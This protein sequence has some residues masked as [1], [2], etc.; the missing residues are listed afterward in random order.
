MYKKSVPVLMYHHIRPEAGMIACTPENFEDQLRWL[1]KQ[2]YRSLSLSEFAQ[3]LQGKEVGK[4]V[5]ITFDDGYLNNWVYAFPLLLKY[6]FNATI[7]LVT[8]WLQ[9]GPIRP[10]MGQSDRLPDCP[11]HHACEALIEQGRSD[12]VIL[13]WSEVRAMRDSGLVEFH[14]HTDTHTRWDLS[15]PEEKNSR[16]RQELVSS[17]ATLQAELGE[18]SPHLCW[19]QGYFDDDY[20]A[21]AR[22][23]GFEYLYTTLAFGRNTNKTPASH[24][25]RFAVR[26]RP[27]KTLGKRIRSSHHPIIGPVFNT[28]KIWTRGLKSRLP[29]S[30]R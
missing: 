27:G 11:D 30:T 20:I 14:S 18:V 8:S 25:H 24:I 29:L 1:Q 4:A 23:V 7:F 16:I 10:Y 9:H 6:Q 13:R 15:L 17:R 21:I 3:H 5:L 2:G 26:N 19:P 28:T 22:D 12:E